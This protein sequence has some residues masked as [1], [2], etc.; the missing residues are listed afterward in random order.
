M[1]VLILSGV[2]RIAP[3]MKRAVATG[4]YAIGSNIADVRAIAS[5]RTAA[6]T[7]F[8]RRTLMAFMNLFVC[9]QIMIVSQMM[10]S[11]HSSCHVTQL[12]L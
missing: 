3:K 1:I 6:R 11:K 2:I 8:A 4:W 5:V 7:K 9:G 10:G 12:Y